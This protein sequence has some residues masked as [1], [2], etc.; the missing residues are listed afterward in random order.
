[1]KHKVTIKAEGDNGSGKSY[2]L[3]KI[4]SFLE[5]EF[6]VNDGS[7]NDKHEIVVENKY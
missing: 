5:K 4:K 6:K 2:L 3:K 7:F 1:M